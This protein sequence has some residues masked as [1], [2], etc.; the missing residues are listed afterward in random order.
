[1]YP[2]GVTA[3]IFASFTGTSTLMGLKKLA[4]RTAST[5]LA[6]EKFAGIMRQVERFFRH[7]DLD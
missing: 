1:M 2:H 5:R 7:P 6:N 4:I 3:I